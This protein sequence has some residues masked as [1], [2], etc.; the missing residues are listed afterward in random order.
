M[1]RVQTSQFESLRALQIIVQVYL[2]L[3][4]VLARC[5]LRS[6]LKLIVRRS[7]HLRQV[8]WLR[9]TWTCTHVPES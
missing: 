4:G 5:L 2:A 3:A 8:R 9:S 6:V 7:W 1:L